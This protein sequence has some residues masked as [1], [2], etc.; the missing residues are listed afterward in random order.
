[1]EKIHYIFLI[2]PKRRKTPDPKYEGVLHYYRFWIQYY[3]MQ[4]DADPIK[5]IKTCEPAIEFP[6][7]N[8]DEILQFGYELGGVKV[9]E[10]YYKLRALGQQYKVDVVKFDSAE[11]YHIHLAFALVAAMTKFKTQVHLFKIKILTI[12]KNIVELMANIGEEFY[13]DYRGYSNWHHDV[14]RVGRALKILLEAVD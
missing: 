10:Y 3:L 2:V 4:H 9:A 1:M 12:N 11:K 7:R 14:L 13:K 6:T 8:S 5:V